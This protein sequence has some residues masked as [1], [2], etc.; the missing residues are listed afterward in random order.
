MNP[1]K[2]FVG[3]DDVHHA[4]H[5]ERAF[6][7]NKRLRN[8]K[9]DF[10]VKDWIMDSGAFSEIEKHGR[11]LLS[12]EEYASQIER[13]STVGNF[14][15]AAT[16]DYM[17]EPFI[18]ART[19]LSVREH[20]LLTVERYDQLRDKTNKALLPVVQGFFPVDYIECLQLYGN[21][22][23]RGM[24]VGVGSVCRRNSDPAQIEDVL[25]A[26]QSKRPDLRLHGFGLKKTA[27]LSPIVR[28]LLY[29]ADS[30]AWSDAARHKVTHCAR[31]LDGE[32]FKTKSKELLPR[33]KIALR[34]AK[35]ITGL[36]SHNYQTAQLFVEEIENGKANEWMPKQV[37]LWM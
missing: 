32:A 1:V 8:R 13:W 35:D 20:Q 14:Q 26:I 18:V 24:W 4:H 17:C 25:M 6:I 11:F 19:G 9:S 12:V 27:L 37:P 34:N 30:M 36:D 29:S 22:L 10:V 3:L 7:S 21:R 15:M 23:T 5:F 16:Q 33:R 28:E 2:F 31:G